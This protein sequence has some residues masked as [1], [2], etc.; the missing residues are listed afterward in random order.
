MEERI[1][2]TINIIDATSTIKI[3][4]KPLL[5]SKYKTAVT[6]KIDPEDFDWNYRSLSVFVN[7]I[8]GFKLDDKNG[9]R[10]QI[11]AKN[12]TYYFFRFVSKKNEKEYILVDIKEGIHVRASKILLDSWISEP[13]KPNWKKKFILYSLTS[14]SKALLRDSTL[15]YY[16]ISDFSLLFQSFASSFTHMKIEPNNFDTMQIYDFIESFKSTNFYEQINFN[17]F[18]K[19][20]EGYL[21]LNLV[22]NNNTKKKL[23]K[24]L[25]ED[26]EYFI[27]G[28]T[29]ITPLAS[30]LV[31]EPRVSGIMLDTTWKL[32]QNYVCSIPTLIIQ[33][34][35]VPIGFTFSLIEDSLIYLDFFRIFQNAYGFAINDIIHIVESDQGP[36]LKAAIDALNCKQLCCLHHLKVNLKKKAFSEQVGNLISATCKQDFKELKKLY[37]TNWNEIKDTKK[38]NEL[39]AVLRKVGLCFEKGKVKIGDKKR[40]EEVSML[41][42]P[43]FKMPS[44]TNQLESTHGHMN[45]QIPRRNSLWPSLHRIIQDILQKNKNFVSYFKQ[46]YMNYKRKIKRICSNTPKNIMKQM[47]KYYK[48]DIAHLTCQ[49]GEAVLLSSMLSIQLPCS[50][51]IFLGA[52]FP[53]I[54]VQDLD[55]NNSTKGELIIEHNYVKS[56]K[57]ELNN[58][59][60][61]NIRKYAYKIIKRYTHCQAKEKIAAYVDEKLIFDEDPTKFVLGYPIKVFD[62]IDQGILLFKKEKQ[63]TNDTDVEKV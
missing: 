43:K 5:C 14:G 44:C 7:E 42:R 51:L 32:L 26:K 33:N 31:C 3:I 25:V 49:C 38:L 22:E 37:S 6:I 54:E 40:W 63:V 35:G 13:Y 39:Q 56:E 52:S 4:S 50:H 8:T 62:V 30:S 29:F 12:E 24:M 55:M 47:I 11:N 34:V 45:S 15:L 61:A 17:R 57:V 53:E 18:K 16:P 28:G 2:Q 46:N 10:L 23:D 59:Y 21:F 27:L 1:K 41:Q 48:T 9:C 20:N 60:F 36:A 19:I 58:D